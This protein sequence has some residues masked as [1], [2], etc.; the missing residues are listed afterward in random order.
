MTGRAPGVVVWGMGECVLVP[1]RGR[2]AW[3]ALA[4]R[5]LSTPSSVPTGKLLAC[6][7]YSVMLRFTATL[8]TGKLLA[9]TS[10]H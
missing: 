4:W 5:H 3:S 2:R 1:E 6:T 8:Y 9:C 7:R 10:H